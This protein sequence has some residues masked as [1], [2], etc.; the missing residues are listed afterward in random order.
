MLRLAR[1][2]RIHRETSGMRSSA[3]WVGSVA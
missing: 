1:I 3:A 2:N